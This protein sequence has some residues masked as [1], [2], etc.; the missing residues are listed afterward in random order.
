MSGDVRF[1]I[2]AKN[3]P[4]ILIAGKYEPLA[5]CVAEKFRATRFSDDVRV[6]TAV[7]LID[8]VGTHHADIGMMLYVD[9]RQNDR[10]EALSRL[11]HLQLL[12]TV[13]AR[14]AVPLFLL[15]FKYNSDF[16]ADTEVDRFFSW[17]GK[18]FRKPPYSYVFKIGEL[19]GTGDRASVVDDFLRQIAA[20]GGVRIS[21]YGGGVEGPEERQADH[22]YARDVGRVVYWFAM[23]RPESGLYELGSGFPRT[24]TALAGAIFRALR[25][26]A[27]I[28]YAENPPGGLG[29]VPAPLSVNL[30]NL[31]R[32]GYRKPFYSVENGV[33]S[34]LM[35]LNREEKMFKMDC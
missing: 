28:T 12:W 1:F 6:R 4:M 27:S 16:T 13:A 15:F 17:T 30:S 32:I 3:E 34:Y 23:H 9:K 24:D 22:V 2:F 10:H 31:R 35:R 5:E 11:E 25:M 8:Y 19:Y 29:M 14:H 21:R 33:K 20:T 26:P 18:Q 7:R